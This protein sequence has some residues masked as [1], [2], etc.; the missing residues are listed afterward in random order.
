MS[1]FGEECK[2]AGIIF[3]IGCSYH[4]IVILC[5][6]KQKIRVK[7]MCTSSRRINLN[8]I[9]IIHYTSN[10]VVDKVLVCPSYHLVAIVVSKQCSVILKAC[11][12]S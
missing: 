11:A 3:Y 1:S 12:G 4:W 7:N 2:S 10:R 5:T 9:C 6:D 8:E